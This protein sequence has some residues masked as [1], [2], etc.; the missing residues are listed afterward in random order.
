M[1][2]VQASLHLRR[3]GGDQ[4]LNG[5]QDRSGKHGG[6][7]CVLWR[8]G[9]AEEGRIYLIDGALRRIQHVRRQRERRIQAGSAGAHGGRHEALDLFGHRWNRSRAVGLRRFF[10]ARQHAGGQNAGAHAFHQAAANLQGRPAVQG[11][12][13][14]GQR[15][16]RVSVVV[17]C[18]GFGRHLHL[19]FHWL[20]T[21]RLDF[22]GQRHGGWEGD[23]R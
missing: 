8:V 11:R 14:A 15:L 16:R 3:R 20:R 23:S 12:H 4:W 19:E 9:H 17:G 5:V 13:R 1:R 22:N 2:A 6:C 10:A 18:C 21:D 7:R